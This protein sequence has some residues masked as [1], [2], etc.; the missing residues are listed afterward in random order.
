MTRTTSSRWGALGVLVLFELR[1]LWRE[2]LCAA[3][4]LGV[5]LCSALAISQGDHQI[6]ELRV[7]RE[8][9]NALLIAQQK[10][11]AQTIPAEGADAGELA[12]YQFY[13]ASDTSHAWSFIALGNRLVEPAVQRIRMLGLQAQLYDAQAQNPENAVPGNFDFAFVAVFLLPL[14]CVVLGHNVRS[15][16]RESGRLG[17]L[18]STTSELARLMR[19]RWAVRAACAYLAVFLPLVVFALYRQIPL[20]PLFWIG[21]CLLS[22]LAIWIILI[23]RVSSGARSS[24]ENAMRGYMLWLALVLVIPQVGQLLINQSLPTALGKQIA[25]AHRRS[26]ANAWDIPKQESFDIFFR[27]HPEWKN[28]PPVLTRFHWKWYYAFHQAADMQLADQARAYNQKVL[29]RQRVADYLGFLSPSVALQALLERMA[30]SRIERVLGK[31]DEIERFH[32]ALRRYFYP[33][34]FEER[35]MRAE[36]FLGAPVFKSANVSGLEPAHAGPYAIFWLLAT[37][38]LVFSGRRAR[39][40][41]S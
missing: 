30:D 41:H 22:Y 18:E 28:T 29:A 11:R 8:R 25:L 12:Y 39:S 5:L 37:I 38:A 1:L 4:L 10:Q 23:N 20:V 24:A 6:T 26:V 13:P 36:D 17:L 7:E 21:L 31:R 33:F 9:V 19:L 34:V 3:A 16:E 27:A 35:R 40:T 2:R 15:S 32:T 14:L